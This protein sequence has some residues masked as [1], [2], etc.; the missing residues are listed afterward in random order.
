MDPVNY[1]AVFCDCDSGGKGYLN[2]EDVVVAHAMMFGRKP[3]KYEL[4]ELLGSDS[5]EQRQLKLDVKQFEEI[6]R[7]RTN[8]IDEDEEIRNMFMAFDANS[9]GFLTL[10]DLQRVFHSVAPSIPEHSVQATF[11]EVDRY[12]DGR[13]SY[14][15]FEFVMKYSLTDK[16]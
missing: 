1:S 11:K 15:D 12:S 7:S 13:L 2:R 6:F 10:E 16:F 9:K 14:R 5:D 8:A 3:T 4:S